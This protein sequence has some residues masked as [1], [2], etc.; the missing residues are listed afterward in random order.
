M[1]YHG[2]I[3][4]QVVLGSK[5]TS[6]LEQ[7]LMKKFIG[8]FL[9]IALTS[10]TTFAQTTK[11]EEEKPKTFADHL[12]FWIFTQPAKARI[13]PKKADNKPDFSAL[14]L[15]F[16]HYQNGD[17]WRFGTQFQFT[18]NDS[19]VDRFRE[20]DFRVYVDRFFKNTIFGRLRVALRL[21]TNE[22]AQE[23]NRLVQLNI[24]AFINPIK[25]NDYNTISG[26]FGLFNKQFFTEEQDGDQSEY[27]SWQYLRWTNTQLS[28]KY[29]FAMEFNFGE[30]HIA[31][32]HLLSVKKNDP[33]G[34]M[35]A[36]VV[37]DAAGINWYPYLTHNFG[38][39]KALDQ[40]GA[41][42]QIFKAF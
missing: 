13:L 11:T 32:G 38:T 25:L 10:A 41:G 36:G 9:L 34:S 16:L 5:H 29:Q 6:I 42:V 28:D 8:L 40:V 26:I 12:N 27:S 33:L 15:I 22:A 30:A 21:P 39:V 14:N 19:N 35:L 4:F 37:F 17:K 31:G 20:G 3:G 23:A 18:L 1:E 24:W 2:W 7:T